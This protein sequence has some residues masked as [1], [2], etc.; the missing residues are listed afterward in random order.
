MKTSLDNESINYLKDDPISKLT[1]EIV[2]RQRNSRIQEQM[3]VGMEKFYLKKV[4]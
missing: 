3:E 2:E 1:G 4:K